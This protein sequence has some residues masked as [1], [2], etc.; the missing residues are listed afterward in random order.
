M[1]ALPSQNSQNSLWV[2]VASHAEKNVATDATAPRN[3]VLD[4]AFLVTSVP[5]MVSHAAGAVEFDPIATKRLSPIF[6]VFP[7]LICAAKAVFAT[8]GIR[9]Y[10]SILR[11]FPVIVSW[12]S[13][14]HFQT[15]QMSLCIFIEKL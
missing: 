11:V 5:R 13:N 1:L 15:I 4:A 6:V 3:D 14:I 10:S 7:L 8:V 2:P 9:L 12:I